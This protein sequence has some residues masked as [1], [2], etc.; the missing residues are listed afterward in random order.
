[1]SSN[2]VLLDRE[3]FKA[4][5]GANKDREFPRWAGSSSTNCPI[6]TFL[7]L[8]KGLR[9]V[10]VGAF[11]FCYDSTDGFVGQI[12]LPPWAPVFIKKLGSAYPSDPFKGHNALSILQDLP[13]YAVQ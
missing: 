12:D 6:A 4:W 5:L 10:S 1:M 9:E 7:T 2:G 11:S 3:E 13:Q 8:G